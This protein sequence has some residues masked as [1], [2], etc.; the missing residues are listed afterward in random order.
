MN[1]I[2]EQTAM[3]SE[4]KTEV[5]EKL[6]DIKVDINSLTRKVAQSDTQIIELKRDLR[7]AE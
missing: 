2:Y 3:L 6:E 4:Y 7:K 5:V 1:A